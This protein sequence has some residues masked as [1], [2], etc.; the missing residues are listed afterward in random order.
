MAKHEDLEI[1]IFLASFIFL[2]AV[3]FSFKL[4]KATHHEK[5]WLAMAIGFL[6]FAIHHWMMIP[7]TF[8]LLPEG[9]ERVIEQVSSIVGSSLFA[10]AT[11]GLYRS[12]KEINKKL[13]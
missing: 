7:L 5:Y 2:I 1:L 4:S 11:H 8:G 6:V 13:Q 12:I 3:Y 10:Y 9:M